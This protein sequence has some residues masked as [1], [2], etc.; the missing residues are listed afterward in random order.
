MDL[1]PGDVNL[2][3]IYA[4]SAR[5]GAV[6]VRALVYPPSRQLACDVTG[7]ARLHV[8]CRDAARLSLSRA[9]ASLQGNVVGAKTRLLNGHGNCFMLNGP[10]LGTRTR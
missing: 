2:R 5:K 10:A 1:A 4:G 6:A 9:R 8:D 7:A 3:A